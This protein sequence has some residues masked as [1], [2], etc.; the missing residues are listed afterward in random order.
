MASLTKRRGVD[1]VFTY[2]IDFY[3]KGKRIRRSTKTSDRKIAIKIRDEICGRI[4]RGSFKMEEV[5]E[6]NIS[7]KDFCNQ[8]EQ[9]CKQTKKASSVVVDIGAL[10]EFVEVVGSTK[11][12][13]LITETNVRTYVAY[14]LNKKNR[15]LGEG[16]YEKSNRT[17]TIN[18]KIQA[19][20]TA[21]NWAM[22]GDR[23]WID[24]NVCSAVKYLKEDKHQP[25][26][27]R[28]FELMELFKVMQQD[29][30]RGREFARYVLFL[31]NTGCRR[32]EALNVTWDMVDFENNMVTLFAFKVNRES[33]L[34]L[35]SEL[36]SVLHDIRSEH[37]DIEPK[38]KVFPFTD[39]YATKRFKKYV[40]K[41][42]LSIDIHLHCLRHTTATVLR[43]YGVA[44]LDIRDVLG[45][46]NV[47]TTQIY[48]RT[49]PTQLRPAL[50]TL[51]F[52]KLMSK[53][54]E[55]LEPKKDIEPYDIIDNI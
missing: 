18:R 20:K 51:Q 12:L 19:I 1:G 30:Q 49:Y 24:T 31:L 29:G 3:Y 39:D 15:K 37:V 2:W 32:S 43:M 54:A 44:L 21:F 7:L 10:K 36:R 11:T 52:K 25:R 42:G 53:P 6:K 33:T 22:I 34:P 40:K 45:H 50:E 16:E 46:A 8:Y 47:T 27:L 35:N 13:R 5:E 14:L 26:F 9:Y 17:T 55:L 38:E 48:S 28:D 23:R 4:A 41:A